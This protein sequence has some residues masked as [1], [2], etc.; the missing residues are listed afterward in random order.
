MTPS[1][2]LE[3]Q[4]LLLAALLSL[5]LGQ[6]SIRIDGNPLIVQPYRPLSV[7]VNYNVVRDRQALLVL[8]TPLSNRCYR[9]VISILGEDGVQ[10][11]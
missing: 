3:V 1:V 6:E 11:E 8:R 10:S 4:G 5:V 7:D 9:T 2:C